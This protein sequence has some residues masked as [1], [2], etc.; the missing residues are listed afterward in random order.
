MPDPPILPAG[1]LAAG[2]HCG[3]KSDPQ[4]HDLS[5]FVSERPS[6]AA[7]VFTT[8]RVC[9]API[10]VCRERVPSATI[11]AVLINS[12]NANAC[13]GQR[14]IDDAK[15]SAKNVSSRLNCQE[16]D[17][18][19]LS[20]GVIGRLLPM[21]SLSAGVPTLI[22]QLANTSDAFRQAARGMMTT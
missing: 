1:F 7:G 4:K 11:R 12:G 9:G 6:V 16:E 5:L 15:S 19:V 21:E 20:T 3:I 17:V 14:G 18:L 8:N 13:T 10:T 2:I 22:N